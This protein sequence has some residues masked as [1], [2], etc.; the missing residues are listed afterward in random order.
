MAA[1]FWIPFLVIPFFLF[2]VLPQ[3]R[4]MQAV[5][6]MQSR[7]AV[8]EEIVTT[9]GIYGTIRAI[10]DDVIDLEIARGVEIRIARRAVG[11]IAADLHPEGT[12]TPGPTETGE[13]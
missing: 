5:G 2:I 9:S 13:S 10:G 3:R 4:Q 7:L 12:P 11:R 6:A 8:G 1:L